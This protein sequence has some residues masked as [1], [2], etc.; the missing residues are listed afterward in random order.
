MFPERLPYMPYAHRMLPEYTWSPHSDSW[1]KLF[2]TCTTHIWSYRMPFR[3]HTYG[4]E[5]QESSYNTPKASRIWSVRSSNFQIPFRKKNGIAFGTSVSLKFCNLY[6]VWAITSLIIV[7]SLWHLVH[8]I[9]IICSC[10][11]YKTL[12]F[13]SKVKVKGEHFVIYTLPGP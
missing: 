6:L 9:T 2:R 8:I 10:V 13:M 11:T 3:K 5:Q 4:A 1:W 7:I 12:D